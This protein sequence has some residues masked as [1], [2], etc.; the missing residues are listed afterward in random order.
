MKTKLIILFLA[1][2]LMSSCNS[3]KKIAIED[4]G[5]DE[6]FFNNKNIPVVK[7]KVLNLTDE[8]IERLKLEYSIVTLFAQDRF[9]ISKNGKLNPDGTFELDIEYA[10]PYQQIWL[11][12]GKLFY[13]G[14]YANSDL[15]IELD[16]DSMRETHA[17]MNGAGVKYAGSDGE[18]NTVLNNHV[19]YEKK[20][21]PNFYKVINSLRRDRNMDYETFLIKYDSIYAVLHNMDDEFIEKNPSSCS[22]LIKNERLSEY[23]A[24]L[25]VRHWNPNEPE[26]SENL[27]E[28][29]INHKPYLISNSG[30]GFY[31]YLFAYL[32]M[33]ATKNNRI[34]YED[35]MGYSGLSDAEKA[36]MV[37]YSGIKAQVREGVSYDTVRYRELSGSLYNMLRDTITVYRNF[38][39]INYIDSL[40]PDSKADLLKL[41]LSSKVEKEKKMILEAALP[42]MNTNWCKEIM[43]SDYEL[44]EKRLASIEKTLN[45]AKRFTSDKNIG[46]PVAVLPF[47][48]K[49]Y[50]VDD[51]NAEELLSNIKTAFYNKALLLDFWA[52][53]CAPCLGDLPYSKKLHDE[54]KNDSIEFVYLCTSR[55]S[56]T[57][58]WKAKITELELGGTHL[59]VESDI[60]NELMKLFSFGGFPS[61]AFIDKRGNYKA[62]AISR[63]SGIKK[64]ELKKLMGK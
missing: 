27:F 23:Y 53:W 50:K 21:Q 39:T 6:Y 40:F 30:A 41:K 58:K 13:A 4:A 42:T 28:E 32:E 46:E 56:D 10:F 61:Y 16:A 34:N 37:E 29:I 47:G 54:L 5:F 59:F 9:Q 48:A 60:E 24:D 64:E 14:I 57:D 19:L 31:N 62:G 25:C 49:L 1:A 51:I 35:F 17:Y 8:E 52:T 12:V 7:G 55:S 45:E 3:E 33:R 26:M 36:K 20:H 15:Y 22:W 11:R 44:S 38:R 63:M 43:K 18:L 2:V